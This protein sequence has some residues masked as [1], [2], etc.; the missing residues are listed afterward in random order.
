MS[1][2]Q[3]RNAVVVKA[4]RGIIKKV[5]NFPSHHPL[6]L[7]RSTLLSLARGRAGRRVEAIAVIRVLRRLDTALLAIAVVAVAG[8][9]R[10]AGVLGL[11][12][13]VRRGRVDP[14]LVAV[15]ILGIRRLLVVVHVVTLLLAVGA[16]LL[17]AGGHP[18]GSIKWLRA[19][20]AATTC[21]DGA[22]DKG[23]DADQQN[24][25][26]KNPSAPVIPVVAVLAVIAIVPRAA[27]GV[28]VLT[29]L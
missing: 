4:F 7:V 19:A 25:A 2:K 18:T 17:R 12:L 15:V 22:E 23:D 20:T 6:R 28:T 26:G 5:D 13:T 16:V 11:L 1:I 24:D 27:V 3:V 9:E 8:S 29:G 21:G 14:A 10:G